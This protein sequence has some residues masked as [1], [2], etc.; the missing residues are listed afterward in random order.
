MTEKQYKSLKNKKTNNGKTLKTTKNIINNKRRY[1][2]M[3]NNKNKGK[4]MQTNTKQ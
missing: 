2:W 4:T 1:K 3:E